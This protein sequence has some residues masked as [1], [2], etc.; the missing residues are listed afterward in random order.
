MRS[1]LVFAIVIISALALPGCAT[2]VKDVLNN[3]DKDC[4]RHYAGSA[5]TGVPASATITFTV[6]CQPS[7]V[8]ATAAQ[9]P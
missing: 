2:D 1:L 8:P 5:A 6:D 4:V 9:K 3:L 7:G